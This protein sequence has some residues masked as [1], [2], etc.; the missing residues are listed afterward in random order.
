MKS[1][2]W[3]IQQQSCPAAHLECWNW[4][5]PAI[6][7]STFKAIIEV[8]E[9]LNTS[10]NNGFAAGDGIFCIRQTRPAVEPSAVLGVAGRNVLRLRRV[11][12]ST[13]PSGCT[14]R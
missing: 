9:L 13:A 5:E 6:Q 7:L 8:E 2:T 14:I 11:C 1:Q 3:E 4:A 10:W 12:D